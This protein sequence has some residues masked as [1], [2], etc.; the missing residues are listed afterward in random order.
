[1]GPG[2]EPGGPLQGPRLRSHL[3]LNANG[4]PP[5]RGDRLGIQ[6]AMRRPR[7]L[8]S[9]GSGRFLR[10]IK[11]PPNTC[12]SDFQFLRDCRRPH[13]GLA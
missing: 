8:T 9:G 7:P 1:M 12:T 13:A 5:H 6:Q 3:R 4:C 2:Q 10:V 11:C